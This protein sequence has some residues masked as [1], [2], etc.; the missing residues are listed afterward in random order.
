[1]LMNNKVLAGLALA[2]ALAAG[3]AQ[4]VPVN[5]LQNGSFESQTP[6]AS[7]PFST[8]TGG[9]TAIDFWTVVDG[10]NNSGNL[11]VLVGTAVTPLTPYQGNY[12]LD[13]T[14]V[15]DATPP[16]QMGVA[17]TFATTLGQQYKLTFALGSDRADDVGYGA[18][19]SIQVFQ[20]IT[21]SLGLFSTTNIGR[22][23]WELETVFFT[24]AG[25]NTTIAM[26]GAFSGPDGKY[27]GLDDVVVTPTPLPSTWLMLLSG[28][29]GLGFFA[30]RGTKKNA[31]ALAV[32]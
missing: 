9:S 25:A 3:T 16:D 1:M 13:L 22:N 5:L 18:P 27:I 31:A 14:G 30:Y 21:I 2:T 29:V 26:I 12:F 4:A 6:G 28:F 24:A 15:G 17:Q 19:A 10:A 8:Y 11:A 23:N 32:A 7:S 20:D